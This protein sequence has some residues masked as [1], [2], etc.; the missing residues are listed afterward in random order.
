MTGSDQSSS[1]EMR[2]LHVCCDNSAGIKI[3]FHLTST[4]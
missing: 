1:V 2:S 4:L 3:C